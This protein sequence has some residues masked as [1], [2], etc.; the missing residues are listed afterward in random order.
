MGWGQAGERTHQ[1]LYKD[2][3]ANAEKLGAAVD[4]PESTYAPAQDRQPT[5]QPE[6]KCAGASEED[7]PAQAAERTKRDKSDDPK[8]RPWG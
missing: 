8:R 5:Y 2:T 3:S 6:T 1:A 4:R 7:Q